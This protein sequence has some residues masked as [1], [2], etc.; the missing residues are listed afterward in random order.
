MKHITPLLASLLSVT[1]LAA[2]AD[3][4]TQHDSADKAFNEMEGKSDKE[5]DLELQR[6]ELE[7]ERLKLELEKKQ[8]AEEKQKAAQPAPAPSHQARRSS[9]KESTFY[10]GLETYSASG[11]RTYKTSYKNGGS[12][13]TGYDSK[14]TQQALKL[15][16]GGLGDNRL[17]LDLIF[18]KDITIDGDSLYESGTGVGLTWDI[19]MSS[20]YNPSDSSNLLPFLRLGFGVGSYKH[21]EENKIYYAED[22][23]SSV[24]LKWGLGIYYQI[25][26]SF[27]LALSYDWLTGAMAYKDANENELTITDQVGGIALGI[28]AHF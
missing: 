14:F 25:N 10:L 27:E 13:S 21:L 12:Y 18:G 6:K 7:I 1:L 11:T 17:A 9:A 24:E 15:G 19:V 2:E 3:Y 8:L 5:K 4:Q 16:F 26:K 28:N 22:T 20:L 23:T